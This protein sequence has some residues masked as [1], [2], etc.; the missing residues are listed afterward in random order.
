M[1]SPF[2]PHSQARIILTNNVFSVLMLASQCCVVTKS[3]IELGQA[4]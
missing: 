3:G 1:S 4:I 2:T